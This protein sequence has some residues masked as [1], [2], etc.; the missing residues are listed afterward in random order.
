[1]G[2]E[3][4]VTWIF[5]AFGWI[6]FSCFQVT[7]EMKNELEGAKENIHNTFLGKGKLS[8]GCRKNFFRL[9]YVF[10]TLYKSLY[11]FTL[12]GSLAAQGLRALRVEFL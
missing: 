6:Q 7:G 5:T 2:V 11:V 1:M 9:C 4:V 12:L 8:T 10:I 3:G